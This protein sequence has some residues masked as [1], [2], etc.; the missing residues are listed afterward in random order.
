MNYSHIK[1]HLHLKRPT[2]MRA[3]VEQNTVPASDVKVQ[4]MQWT[5][6]KLQDYETHQ[7]SP[8]GHFECRQIQP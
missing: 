2:P 8:K 3:A 4:Q 1:S 7:A 6:V 5:T